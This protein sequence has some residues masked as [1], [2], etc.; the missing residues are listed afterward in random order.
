MAGIPLPGVDELPEGPRRELTKELHKLYD[1]VG[2]PSLRWIE[3]AVPKDAGRRVVSHS[4]IGELLHGRIAKWV[5]LEPVVRALA[6]RQDPARDPD[7]EARR[8]HQLWLAVPQPGETS[9]PPSAE[10]RVRSVYVIGG[11]TGEE[12][13]QDLER[14]FSSPMSVS[15]SA[16]RSRAVART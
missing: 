8:F 10:T 14:R 6:R 13:Y 9:A 12:K 16:P 4:Q 1:G 15:G 2:R 7:S 5:T 3:D 11:V